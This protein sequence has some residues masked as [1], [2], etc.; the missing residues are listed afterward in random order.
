[1]SPVEGPYSS[2]R[3]KKSW[4]LTGLNTR[5]VSAPLLLPPIAMTSSSVRARPASAAMSVISQA[6]FKPWPK[7]RRVLATTSSKRYM[8]NFLRMALLSP[9]KAC[10]AVSTTPP[11]LSTFRLFSSLNSWVLGS[12]KPVKWLTAIILIPLNSSVALTA[13]LILSFMYRYIFVLVDEM[14]RMRRVMMISLCAC[15][16][17]MCMFFADAFRILHLGVK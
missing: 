1:M 6:T 3:S 8:L 17:L 9:E 5:A 12:R 10:V 7:M 11:L 15:L 13:V 16:A 2:L 14:M 4:E